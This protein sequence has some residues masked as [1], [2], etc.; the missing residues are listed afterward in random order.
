MNFDSFDMTTFWETFV[1]DWGTNLFLA[2]ITFIIG[3]FVSKLISKGTKTL[4]NKSHMD[5]ML[6]NFILSILNAL[7]LLFVIIASLSQLG[8]DTTS[9]VA[10]LAAAGL[11]VGLA[12]K[13][14]L[15]NFAAGV[16]LIIFKPFKIGNYV[17]AAGTAGIVE[18]IGIFSSQFRT[19][20]NKEVIIPNGKI[21]QG[22]ITNY[23]AK[24]TRRVDMEFGIGYDDDIQ[25]AKKILQQLIEA[26]DR[27]L[28]EP[29]PVIALSELGESSLNFIVR[30]WVK[31]SDYWALKW[32]MNEKVKQ[33]FDD[34]DINIPYPQMD[35][36]M[37]QLSNE[38][39]SK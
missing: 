3:R 22:T 31:A 28:K 33:A 39:N 5:A 20:D 37:T 25:Q 32:D 26:D 9:L 34:A 7:L 19:G 17:E 10:L 30:P 23:S 18:N 13:D 14:S 21:Y 2:I 27:V 4:L 24:D 1:V 16:M 29:E 15:Q 6:V 35:V 36:H 12:L 38:S 8:V 11:A